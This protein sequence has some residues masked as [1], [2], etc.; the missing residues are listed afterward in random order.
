MSRR[1]SVLLVD[2][3]ALVRETLARVLDDTPDLAV[4]AQVG[5]AE[6][7]VDRAVTLR[8][9][10]V[11][12][13]IDMPGLTPFQAARL[14]RAR[15]PETRIV[16]L[17]AFSHDRYIE[18][19]LSVGASGY[20]TKG[21]SVAAIVAALRAVAAGRPCFAADIKAR[22]VVD[23]DGVRLARP[24]C[25]RSAELSKR[26][27]EVLRYLAD[28]LSKKEIAA[29]THLSERTV[30]RHCTNVMDKLDIHDRVRLARFAVREGYVEA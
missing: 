21:Q 12:M 10:L 18:Q 3:H 5:E 15:C 11:L 30:N 28:G 27:V 13:D 6:A 29:I 7:A 4:A 19:A 9:D 17:S 23:T 8:P 22:L 14:I 25:S 2:D 20:L 16:F 24:G 26:E 1:V